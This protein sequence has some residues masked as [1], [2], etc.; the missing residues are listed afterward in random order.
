MTDGEACCTFCTIGR[1]IIC[2]WALTGPTVC[3]VPPLAGPRTNLIGI[4]DELLITSILDWSL[5][6]DCP[7]VADDTATV[8]VLP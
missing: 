6:G 5:M 8:V 2:G 1:L 4:P 3:T 7:A